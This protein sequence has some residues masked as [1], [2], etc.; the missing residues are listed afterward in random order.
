MIKNK[1][2]YD[3]RTGR[4]TSSTIG[5]LCTNGRKDGELGAPFYKRCQ[6]VASSRMFGART[7]EG[8]SISTEWGILVENY[9]NKILEK[10]GITTGYSS[11]PIISNMEEFEDWVCGSPDAVSMDTVYDIKCYYSITEYFNIYGCTVDELR[12]IKPLYFWQLVNN[13][14]LTGKEYAELVCFYPTKEDLD[15]ILS[16]NRDEMISYRISYADESELPQL[17]E[18]KEDFRLYRLRWEVNAKDTN[19]LLSRINLA[20]KEVE[21][22]ISDKLKRINNG[23]K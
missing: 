11:L 20:K 7:I 16:M 6:I 10:E 21:R 13:A 15:E 3:I 1:S 23:N 8:G 9:V 2:F 22:L 18:G 17:G 12:T 14:I 19:F 5:D 4:F